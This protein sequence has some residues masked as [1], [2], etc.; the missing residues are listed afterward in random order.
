MANVLVVCAH[1]DDEVLG[2]GGTLAEHVKAGDV[3]QPV[4]FA[5]GSQVRYG[6]EQRDQLKQ[7]CRESCA[8]LGLQVPEFVG[9]EDQRLDG[10]VQIE[11]TQRIEERLVKYDSEIVYGHHVGD[12]NKDHQVLHDATLVACRPKPG[13]QVKQLLSFYVPSSTDWAPW[14]PERAF[15]P[16]WFVDVS[17]TMEA[18]LRAVGKYRSETPDYP[19]P[20]SLEAIEAQARFWGS[21]VGVDFAEAFMLVRKLQ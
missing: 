9:L 18:K 21:S 17:A 4:I 7:A 13:G 3:V 14:T 10:Y 19:H 6:E 1:P 20:R 8:V 11:L 16:N 15:L 2:L 12:V 5:D